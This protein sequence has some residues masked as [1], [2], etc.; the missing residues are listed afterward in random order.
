MYR[1]MRFPADMDAQLSFEPLPA[2]GPARLCPVCEQRM[3]SVTLERIPLDRCDKHGIWFDP[4]ELQRVLEH[5]GETLPPPKSAGIKRLL[6][7]LLDQ[8]L[9]PHRKWNGWTPRDPG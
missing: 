6:G 1:D 5:A 7:S 3:S 2:Q 4:E 8:I 9:D